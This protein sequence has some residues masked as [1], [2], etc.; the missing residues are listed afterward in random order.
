MGYKTKAD[1]KPYDPAQT[2]LP[3]TPPQREWSKEQL[4]ARLQKHA[5]AI[6][7]ATAAARADDR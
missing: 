2:D 3:L 5:D 7:K 1:I 6:E 4:D